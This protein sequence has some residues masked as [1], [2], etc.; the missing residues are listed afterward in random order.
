MILHRSVVLMFFNHH[1]LEITSLFQT[2]NLL[3]LIVLF[4][5]LSH[6]TTGFVVFI[7]NHIELEVRHTHLL[8]LIRASFLHSKSL[9]SSNV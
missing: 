3:S 7:E 5:F 2:L 6:S 1:W 9:V 8:S 4:G